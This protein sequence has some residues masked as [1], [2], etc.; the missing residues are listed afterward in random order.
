[1][2]QEYCIF[3]FLLI[4]SQQLKDNFV[5]GWIQ[6]A[7]TSL[8]LKYN[9]RPQRIYRHCFHKNPLSQLC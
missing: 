1:M 4:S 9:A 3:L 2:N 6:T 7:K 5:H 8:T